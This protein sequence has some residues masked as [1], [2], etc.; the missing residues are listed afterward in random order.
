MGPKLMHVPSLAELRLN[1][2]KITTLTGALKSLPKLSILDI[3]NN[4]I[5]DLSA[6][7]P[8]RG[9]LWIKSISVLGNP[10][11]QQDL[12]DLFA[13]LPKLEIINDKRQAGTSKKKRKQG[14]QEIGHSEVV[15]HGRAFQGTRAVFDDS[16]E[17]TQVQAS[18]AQSAF[19]RKA[20]SEV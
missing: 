8:L 6:L 11:A 10:V 18:S 3:G 1:G 17:E 13:T 20:A 19:K 16:D 4:L 14:D 15:V 12:K 2:N 9:M 5:T 7:E